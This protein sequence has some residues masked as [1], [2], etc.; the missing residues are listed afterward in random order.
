ME[1]HAECTIIDVQARLG[2]DRAEGSSAWLLCAWS[3]ERKHSHRVW[4]NEHRTTKETLF[5]LRRQARA[6]A[7]KDETAGGTR[8]TG[9][10][11]D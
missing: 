11:G 5:W 3:Q 4:E 2:G 8:G 1:C 10:G 7:E 9:S 6:K